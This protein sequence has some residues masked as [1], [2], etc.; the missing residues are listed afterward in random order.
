[1]K[2]T[3]AWLNQFRRPRVRYD[4]RADIHEAF[5]RLGCTLICWQ[6]LDKTWRTASGV[7]DA[8]RQV[9][10]FL[11]S[12]RPRRYSGAS[13]RPNGLLNP[14]AFSREKRVGCGGVQPAEFGVFLDRCVG[15]TRQP[16]AG[17][18][19]NRSCLSTWLRLFLAQYRGMS[20]RLLKFG[21]AQ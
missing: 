20:R 15:G 1:V 5:L 10:V 9:A 14:T 21:A 13:G 4:E 11:L 8:H 12:S 17:C 19:R 18:D 3:F 2:R 6:S 16:A 7:R